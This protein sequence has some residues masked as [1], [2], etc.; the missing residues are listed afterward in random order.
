MSY[1]YI[2]GPVN[3]R[4]LGRSLGVDLFPYNICSLDC[5]YCEC[6]P[7]KELTLER[8][9]YVDTGEV[10]KELS[11]YLKENPELDY[12]T[13]SGSGEPTLHSGLGK[14]LK[15]IKNN[16]SQYNTAL[17][18]N[19]TLLNREVRE[20]IKDFDLI[21][22]SLDGIS[23]EAFAKIDRP[24]LDIDI[25]EVIENIISLRREQNGKIWLE[26]FLVPGINDN[27]VEFQL[28]KKA[29][30]RINPEK[31]QLNTLDRPG[32]I[33]DIKKISR[34]RIEEIAAFFKKDIK[35]IEIEIY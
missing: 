18:T 21:V 7:T 22:P 34:K 5:I 6:G 10:L 11:S 28:F 1:K 4:R 25:K 9:E 24:H 15:F 20:E 33:S 30:K 23:V 27:E 32:A 16:F 13:F 29:V 35:D 12:I 31:V 3:S 17:L 26:I 19:S 2:Y 14:I 8:K